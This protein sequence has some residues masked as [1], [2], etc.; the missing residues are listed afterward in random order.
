MVNF[1]GISRYMVTQASVHKK[2]SSIG[3]DKISKHTIATKWSGTTV[4]ELTLCTK[5]LLNT[6][7]LSLLCG[8]LNGT[9]WPVIPLRRRLDGPFFSPPSILFDLVW[10]QRLNSSPTFRARVSLLNCLLEC[11][12]N[13]T[14]TNGECEVCLLHFSSLYCLVYIYDSFPR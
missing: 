3:Y 12:L 10:A 13:D 8:Q 11:S 2:Y 9:A 6:L 7:G 14:N 1:V 4:K 5:K